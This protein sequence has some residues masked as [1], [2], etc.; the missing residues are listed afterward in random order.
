MQILKDYIGGAWVENTGGRYMDVT[1]PST[2]EVIAQVP[3]TTAGHMENAIASAKEAFKTWSRIPMTQKVQYLFTFRNEL[4]ARKEEFAKLIATDQGKHYTDALAEMDR[5]IQST[6]TCCG[7]PLIMRGDKIMVSTRVEAEIRREPIGVI[8]ALAPFNFPAL[9]CGWFVPFA[10]VTG[11]TMVFKASE[12][13]PMFMQAIA[14]V[15]DRMGL[16]AGVFNLVNGDAPVVTQMLE[17]PDIAAMAFVG[18]SKVGQIIAEGCAKTNKKSMILAGAKNTAIVEQSVNI[19][20]FVKNFKNACFG[21]AGQ[22]C[23]AA[24]NIVVEEAVYDSV[25]AAMIR[26]AEETAVG[27]ANDLNVYMGPVISEAAVKRIHG[28]IERAEAEGGKVIVDG[29]NIREKLPEANKNGFFVGPTII[30]GVTKD[31]EIAKEEVFGPVVAL[32][33]VKSYKEGIDLINESVYGNGGSIFTESGIVAQDF[34]INTNSG[35]IGVNI[36]VPASMPY[37]PF[38]GTKGSL[39]GGQYKAQISDALEFFTKRKA[40]TIQYFGPEDVDW[41][42]DFISEFNVNETK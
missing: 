7:F 35:M 23:M 33:K 21:A 27:D 5:I 9:V 39:M 18:S 16:P 3:V 14:D 36:G 40:C 42:K 17:S 4:V 31:F 12:Q 22:R 34:L 38:G 10:L 8:G 28:F 6:E 20:G 41:T 2:G 26:A 29:R 37:L 25:R 15:F 11:N 19:S 30:E 24:A 13:S 1:N 32:I